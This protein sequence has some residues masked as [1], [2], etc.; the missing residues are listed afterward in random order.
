[1]AGTVHDKGIV[2]GADLDTIETAHIEIEAP[3]WINSSTNECIEFT[4]GPTIRGA[5][6]ILGHRSDSAGNYAVPFTEA[7]VESYATYK[8]FVRFKAPAHAIK[9]AETTVSGLSGATGTAASLIPVGSLVL[10][11]TARVTT[12]VTS[13]AGTSFKIGHAGDTD[14]WGATVAF[15][16]N[17]VTTGADFVATAIAHFAAATD[18]VLTCNGGTFTAGAVR[19][20]VWYVT[21]PS[22]TLYY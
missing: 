5:G 9:C 1:V 10:G 19:L 21:F 4:G 17:T 2:F 8:E 3:G 20:K 12:L 16:L 18:V 7:D 6:L 14:A 13:G 11:I 15:A 22:P